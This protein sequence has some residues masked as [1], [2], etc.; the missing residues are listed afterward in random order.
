MARHFFGLCSQFPFPASQPDNTI[1][2]GLPNLSQG[3]WLKAF[4]GILCAS[5]STALVEAALYSP[6]IA[7]LPAVAGAFP[8]A[9]QTAALPPCLNGEVRAARHANLQRL[10]EAL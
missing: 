2:T 10:S 3:G 7:G 6:A 4:A 1:D 9:V 5:A 8:S